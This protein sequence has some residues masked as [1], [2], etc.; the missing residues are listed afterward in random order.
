MNPHSDT[1]I[2][3]PIIF[4]DDAHTY[5]GAQIALG[6]AIR[7]LL[8]YRPDR[9]IVCVCT[10]ASRETIQ[11]FTGEDKNLNFVD[12]PPALPLNIFAFPLRLLSFY[13]LLAP[14]ARQGDRV[15]WFNL[16]GIEFCLAPLLVLKLWG[17]R[18]VAWLHNGETF[19]FYNANGSLQRRLISR[20]R[21]AAARFVFPLY[22]RIVTPSHATEGALK[23]RLRRGLR[24]STGFLYPIVAVPP[25]EE[26]RQNSLAGSTLQLWIIGRVEYVHKNNIAAVEIMKRLRERNVSVC[27]SVV[28]EGP[29]LEHLKRSVR[30]FKLGEWVAFHGWQ[31]NPWTLI[32]KEAIVLLPSHYEGMPLVATEAMMRGIR[33]VTSPLAVFYEGVPHEMIAR[34]FST[35]AFMEKI[36]DVSSMDDTRVRSL[37]SEALMKFSENS[38][39]TKF[40]SLS[41]AGCSTEA[42]RKD[43]HSGGGNV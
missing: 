10:P 24:L 5:G 4:V 13:R 30:V 17:L 37:Y 42:G 12:C 6:W 27:L 34:A 21:D 26:T 3:E 16:A 29:D 23:S 11:R 33:I 31:S 43:N 9:A 20:I 14:L 38:F 7:A 28:G 22:L 18:P 35:E 39:V 15:W 8:R 40:E 36:A 41:L 19:R 25:K 2:S 32:P 1:C